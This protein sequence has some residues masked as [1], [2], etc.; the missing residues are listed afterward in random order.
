MP[1]SPPPPRLPP[2]AHLAAFEAAVRLGGYATAAQAFGVT[3]GAIRAR[4]RA[5]EAAWEVTL[6]SPLPHGVAP[7]REAGLL[8]AEVA[9][10]FARLQRA[11]APLGTAPLP[12]GALRA[13]EAALRCDGFAAAGEQ[14]GVTAGAIAAQIARVEDWAGTPLFTRHARGVTATDRAGAVLPALSRA[15]ASLSGITAGTGTAPVRIAA[16]PAVA[17]LWLAPRLPA[18]RTALPG[19]RVSVTALER[20]P[21]AKRAPYDLALFFAETGGQV[22]AQD[23]LIPVCAPGLAGRFNTPAD[24]AGL[25]CLSDSAWAGDWRLWAAAAMPGRPV[26]RGVEHSLYA[27][28]VDEAIAGAGVLMG[29]KALLDRHLAAGRLVAPVGPEVPVARGLRLTRLR[30]LPRGGAA[31]RVAAWLL[32]QA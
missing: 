2:L 27:L 1:V 10:G 19:V 9:Q 32:A 21:D 11:L 15:L 6:F 8:A 29:H 17:Q 25:P 31:A 13:F 23:A 4:V 3:P 26:P 14:L 30:P 22:L 7:T 12:L 16:L 18:L 5:L 20:L 28:A 24:L